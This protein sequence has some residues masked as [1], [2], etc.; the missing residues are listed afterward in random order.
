MIIVHTF[1]VPFFW[2]DDKGPYVIEDGKRRDLPSGTTR[3]D[4]MWFHRPYPGGKNEALKIQVDWDVEGSGGRK[5]KVEVNDG[6]WSC[7]CH[8]FKFSGNKR[9]CK[10][11][12]DFRSSYL[13]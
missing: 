9:T 2:T 12:E 11:V 8:A 6:E 4:I 13:S 5:Y 1:Q 7:N 10:H 3:K